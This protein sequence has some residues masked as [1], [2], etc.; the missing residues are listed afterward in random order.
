MRARL[1][2]VI[3]DDEPLAR[4]RLTDLLHSR[5]VEIVAEARNGREAVHAVREHRPDL[6]FL[7]IQMPGMS[8][9][10]VVAE[11]GASELPATIFVTAYDQYALKAFEVA[12][13]D[14]LVKPFDDERFEQAFDRATKK[15]RLEEVQRVSER[16][17]SVLQQGELSATASPTAPQYLERVAV[18]SRGQAR[19]VPVLRIDYITAEGPYAQIH[20]GEKS[21]SIRERMQVLEEK[22]DPRRF[23]RVHRSTIVR[24]DA[25][26][27]LLHRA[28]GD[29]SVRM[30]DGTEL[31][32]SRARRD[33]LAE[34]LGV[35]R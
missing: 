30:K 8:G 4:A 7:D 14:Y 16:L 23:F 13:V 27:V 1:R 33:E 21:Y 10:E 19:I 11:L 18:E 31:S 29:Y 26:D 5:N 34:R 35:A 6:L 20:V 22:L 15:L 28:G 12:A 25:V 3:A 2:V 17:V 9:I 24:L 32:V